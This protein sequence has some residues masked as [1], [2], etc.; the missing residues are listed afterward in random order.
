M[1]TPSG[2][3]S[4][5]RT[6]TKDPQND[7]LEDHG[8]PKTDRGRIGQITPLTIDNVNREADHRE[9]KRASQTLKKPLEIPRPTL[10]TI[11]MQNV[12]K[13]QS[14]AGGRAKAIFGG[15]AKRNISTRYV[16]CDPTF[17]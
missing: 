7:A 9:P 4:L 15:V 16:R 5:T 1:T 13:L 2:R 12:E 14:G 8:D 3:P 6:A 17:I 10:A 11:Q